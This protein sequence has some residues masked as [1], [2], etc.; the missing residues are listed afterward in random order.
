[1][2]LDTTR[3]CIPR[4]VDEMGVSDGH[5]R[6]KIVRRLHI[7]HMGEVKAGRAAERRYYWPSMWQQVVQ[8]CKDC[9]KTA[10]RLYD[11]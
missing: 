2:T 10:Q 4:G 9:A 6:R 7:P 3:V 8:E 5:L 1:M 11:D